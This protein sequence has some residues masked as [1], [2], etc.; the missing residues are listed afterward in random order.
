MNGRLSDPRI[1]YWTAF[2][3]LVAT[4]VA[5]GMWKRM[6]DADKK[7]MLLGLR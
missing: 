5:V 3:M 6:T 7:K 4:V 1:T 2:A